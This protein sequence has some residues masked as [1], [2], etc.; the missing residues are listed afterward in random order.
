MKILIT[1]NMG[2]IGSSVVTNLRRVYPDAELIGLDTGYFA[3]CLTAAKALPETRIDK[4]FFCDVRGKIPDE[5][6]NGVDSIVHLAAIS[7][8]PMGN[9]FEQPTI[10]IN[11]VAS[12]ELAEKAK[13]NGVRS[14]VFASSCSIYGAVGDAPRK[15]NDP[16]NPLT[17]YA[18]SKVFV[19]SQL[20]NIADK[21]FIVTCLRFSTACGMSDRLRLD[22][23]LN[24]FVANA[25]ATGKIILL[26]DGSAWRPLIH[27]SD[28]ARAIEWA[29]NRD[30]DNGGNFLAVNTGS[31]EWNYQIK[32]LANSCADIIGG[33]TVEMKAGASPDKRSYKVNFDRFHELAPDHQPKVGLK[34]A[35]KDL[36]TGLT[37]INFKDPDFRST[38]FMRL[39]VLTSHIETGLLD[40]D[41]FWTEKARQNR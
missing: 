27:V 39:R 25:L 37:A 28:M 12:V 21:N 11:G 20:S 1:G 15:E 34:D 38:W 41:L 33:V 31:D 4:Q 32:D 18:K 10:G 19:E 17:T 14:F 24:D 2:Y 6:L 9:R 23:V 36:Q 13:K 30:G 5:A 29:M 40:N 8:D 7:N 3:H 35:I 26:S 16:L 22:L